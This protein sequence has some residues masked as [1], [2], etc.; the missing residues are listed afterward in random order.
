MNLI[1]SLSLAVAFGISSGPS[2]KT[3]FSGRWKFNPS[4]SKNVGMM[5]GL[6]LVTTIQQTPTMLVVT[7]D[8]KFSGQSSTRETRYDL[9]GKMVPNKSVMG[10]DSETVTRW[11]AE[12]LVTT[13]KIPGAIA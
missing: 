12:K 1:L 13:W 2:A 7:D 6:D 11:S 5:S 8:S 4:I 9:N 3:D 10:E